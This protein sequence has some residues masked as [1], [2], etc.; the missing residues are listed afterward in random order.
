MKP[1]TVLQRWISSTASVLV[2]G[3]ALSQVHTSESLVG[4]TFDD[5]PHPRWTMQ[6][7][8]RLDEHGLVATF[9]VVGR[10]VKE[11]PH[12]VRETRRRGHEIGT[13]LYWHRR[14]NRRDS[15][16]LRQEIIRSRDELQ[17]VLGEPIRF[18]RF[19]YGERGNLTARA[20]HREF[21]LLPIHWSFSSLDS[22]ARHAEEIVQRVSPRLRPGA[23]ILMHDCLADESQNLPDRYNPDRTAML[24]FVRLLGELLVKKGLKSATLSQLMQGGRHGNVG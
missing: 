20:V 12:I 7:L 4:L 15:A 24:A 22:R 9:F 17:Q 23:I 13:H 21:G 6:L 14:A 1:V 16:A 3:G 11:F 8:D 18:L 10:T 2:R 19:P 5:G